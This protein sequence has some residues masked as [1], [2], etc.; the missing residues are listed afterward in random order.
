MAERILPSGNSLVKYE[1]PVLVS[2][3]ADKYMKVSKIICFLIN[4]FLK[5]VLCFLFLKFFVGEIDQK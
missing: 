5:H 3:H 4:D 2:K 1:N